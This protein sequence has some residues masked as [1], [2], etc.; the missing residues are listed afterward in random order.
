VTAP[1]YT[2]TSDL[3]PVALITRIRFIDKMTSECARYNNKGEIYLGYL[4]K[5]IK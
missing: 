4:D 5:E 3:R 2:P 1:S